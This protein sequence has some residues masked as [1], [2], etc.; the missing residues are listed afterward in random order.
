MKR[1]TKRKM[2]LIRNMKK[3]SKHKI[4]KSMSIKPF[5]K[6]GKKGRARNKS[7]LIHTNI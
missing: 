1:K 6:N 7:E 5:K 4:Y 2:K 3:K